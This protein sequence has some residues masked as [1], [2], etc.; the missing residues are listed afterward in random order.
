MS[1]KARHRDPVRPTHAHTAWRYGHTRVVLAVPVEFPFATRRWALPVLVDPHRAPAPN[2]AEKRPHRTP[3]QLTCRLLRPFRLRNPGRRVIFVGDSGFGT[4]EVARFCHRHR[5]RLTPV[6]KLHP[7]ANPFDPPARRPRV[8]R[9][10]VKGVRRRKPREAVARTRRLKSLRV[11]WYGGGTRRVGIASESARWYKAGHGLVPLRRVSVR[12]R[13]ATHRDEYLDSTGPTLR[14]AD[15]IGL[16]CGRWNLETTLRE[17]SSGLGLESTRGWGRATVLRAAPCPF[18]LDSVVALLDD[19]L[20]A[21][22]RIGAIR[23]P[24]KTA[25]TFSDA[26][27]AVRRWIWA[28]STLE[29]ADPQGDVAK[30]PPDL[31]ELLL[32][33]PAFARQIKGRPKT[34][35][36]DCSGSGAS[37]RTACCRPSSSRT[38]RRRRCAITSASGPTWS[39]CRG[40]TSS[41]CRRRWS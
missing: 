28:E 20:P 7:D 9:P 38:R 27:T 35:R 17:C 18:G 36:R 5:D 19:A 33:A 3:A 4:R 25:V 21:E 16:Y 11:E 2:D 8:G 32:T 23:R 39:A 13:T 30:R 10:P 15:L 41:G 22:K 12:D 1:G 29:Q 37:T 6:G 34:D 31:R 40:N 26:L 14:P 24:G